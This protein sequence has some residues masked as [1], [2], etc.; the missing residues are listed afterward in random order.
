MKQEYT[1]APWSYRESQIE[2]EFTISGSNEN[3]ASVLPIIGRTHNWPDNC[4]ANARLMSAAPE[5]LES[6]EEII[7]YDG[8]ADNSLEDQSV[9]ERALEA[10]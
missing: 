1:P 2:G 3:G 8:G 7:Y 6:L 4:L 5:L 9:M 10:I